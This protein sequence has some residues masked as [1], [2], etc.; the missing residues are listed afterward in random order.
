MCYSTVTYTPIYCAS[1]CKWIHVHHKRCTF[2]E[3]SISSHR[4]DWDDI[5]DP[6]YLLDCVLEG[7][8]IRWPPFL[9]D[10]R[11]YEREEENEAL[12]IISFNT[13]FQYNSGLNKGETRTNTVGHFLFRLDWGYATWNRD[14]STYASEGKQFKCSLYKA[15][16]TAA[17]IRIINL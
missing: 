8:G 11:T 14:Y 1:C 16:I 4:K 6:D 13:Y 3:M 17:K 12:G 5:A 7:S 9:R 10:L 15:L 2:M